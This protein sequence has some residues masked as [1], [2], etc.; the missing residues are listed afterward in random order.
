MVLIV[1]STRRKIF[2]SIREELLDEGIPCAVADVGG[3]VDLL[4]CETV[5]V[6]EAYLLEDVQYI[7]SIIPGANIELCVDEKRLSDTARFLFYV[8]FGKF[9][10]VRAS[11]CRSADDNSFAIYSKPVYFTKTEKLIIT[12]LLLSSEWKNAECIA[13]YC[14][15]K[16]RND[17]GSIGVHICNINKKTRAAVGRDIIECRRFMGYRI[18]QI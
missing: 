6:A 11:V 10:D 17:R 3:A 9:Q 8:S 16:G 18:L 15:R 14:K 13:A 5:L 7:C 12:M 2:S 1:D 4:P